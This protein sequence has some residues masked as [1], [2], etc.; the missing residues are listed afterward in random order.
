MRDDGSG[1]LFK[2]RA[3]TGKPENKGQRQPQSKTLG[4]LKFKLKSNLN[5]KTPHLGWKCV[6]KPGLPDIF[7][8]EEHPDGVED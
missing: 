4:S 2:T 3:L 8:L 1:G 6:G 7:R 5:D